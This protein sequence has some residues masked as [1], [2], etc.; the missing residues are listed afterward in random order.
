MQ[1]VGK[2]QFPFDK[3]GM[4]EAEDSAKKTGKKVA[5][6]KPVKKTGK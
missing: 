6:K 5:K 4:A 1:K 3:A 2:K